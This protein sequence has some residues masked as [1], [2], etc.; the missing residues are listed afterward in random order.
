MSDLNSKVLTPD[1]FKDLSLADK[2]DALVYLSCNMQKIIT[3][4]VVALQAA[5]VMG[6]KP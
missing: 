1:D 3:D 6:D 4:I 2:V 5:Q